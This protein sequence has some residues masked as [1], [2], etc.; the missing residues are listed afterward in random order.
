MLIQKI[1]VAMRLCIS[2]VFGYHSACLARPTPFPHRLLAIRGGPLGGVGTQGGSEMDII[3]LPQLRATIYSAPFLMIKSDT[4]PHPRHSVPG[5]PAQNKKSTCWISVRSL[6]G[7]CA[8]GS[9]TRLGPQSGTG[10]P[11]ATRNRTSVGPWTQ[12]L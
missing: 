4:P 6:L 1:L 9:P 11:E 3:V 7:F 5:Q 2:F 10:D 8:V 12:T